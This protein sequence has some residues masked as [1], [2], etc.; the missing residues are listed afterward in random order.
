MFRWPEK[1]L[2]LV[3]CSREA[4]VHVSHVLGSPST[5]FHERVC[6]WHDILGWKNR[7]ED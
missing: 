6:G 2:L 5:C 4:D 1:L 7:L 3:T